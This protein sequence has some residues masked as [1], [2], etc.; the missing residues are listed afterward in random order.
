V[1]DD[2]PDQKHVLLYVAGGG[3]QLESWLLL[4]HLQDMRVTLMVPSDSV[5]TPWMHDHD[6]IRVK[7]IISRAKPGYFG[8]ARRAAMNL[9]QAWH[10]IRAGRP[11]VIVCIGSSICLPG[12]VV[13]M[14]H[15]IPRVF[16]ESI[17][18]TDTISQTGQLVERLRLASRFYVQWAGQVENRR[19]RL[20]RGTIL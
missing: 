19:S 4:Q 8:A 15:G 17:T 5:L 18:R 10:A 20:Y 13:A 12:F 3:F 11:D 16:L 14:L 6:V 7:P 2:C 1:S 9:A